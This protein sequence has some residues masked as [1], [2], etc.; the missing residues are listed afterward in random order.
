M[1]IRVDLKNNQSGY[2]HFG[3]I[4][5][6]QGFTGWKRL[7]EILLH[8]GELKEGETVESFYA[9][10]DGIAFSIEKKK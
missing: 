2:P 10:N 9:S 1:G 8:S 5:G 4:S 7:E 6:L 3:G